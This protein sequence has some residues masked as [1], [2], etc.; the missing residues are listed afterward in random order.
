MVGDVTVDAAR[1]WEELVGRGVLEICKVLMGLA[2]VKEAR[3][4]PVLIKQKNSGIGKYKA[5]L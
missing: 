4:G 1:D 3:I 5:D 2:H